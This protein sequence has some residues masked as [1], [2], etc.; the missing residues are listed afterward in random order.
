V[1]FSL[2]NYA[3]FIEVDPEGALN[4]T[5]SKFIKRFQKM[6]KIASEQGNSLAKMTLE[7]MDA[8]WNEVKKEI[9]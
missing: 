1:L 9:R 2:A 8:I 7:E 6:E 4:K 5:N 3:R